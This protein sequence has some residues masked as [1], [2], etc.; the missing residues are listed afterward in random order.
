[1]LASLGALPLLV[2]LI[3][4]V[5]SSQTSSEATGSYIGIGF[6][7]LALSVAGVSSGLLFAGDR[8]RTLHDRMACTVCVRGVPVSRTAAARPAA[9][10]GRASDVPA[11]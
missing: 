6:A 4:D 11:G 9:P 3:G 10:A 7:F 5:R 1:V 2:S 8:N